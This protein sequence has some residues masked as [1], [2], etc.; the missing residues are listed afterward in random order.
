MEF[1]VF[2]G[3]TPLY[4]ETKGMR[5]KKT[6]KTGKI[7]WRFREISSSLLS[8]RSALNNINHIPQSFPFNLYFNPYF[9]PYLNIAHSSGTHSGHCRALACSIRKVY[10]TA[11]TTYTVSCR[12]HF[13]HSTTPLGLPQLLLFLVPFL[14]P[15]LNDVV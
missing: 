15:W 9:N 12:L 5:M 8:F 1:H 7:N 4:G 6:L 13:F 11:A 3:R 2:T 14:M 10:R